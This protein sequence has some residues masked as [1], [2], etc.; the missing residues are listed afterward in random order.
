MWKD[1]N[2]KKNSKKTSRKWSLTFDKLFTTYLTLRQL[3]VSLS[4]E[5]VVYTLLK[6]FYHKFQIYLLFCHVILTF[7]HFCKF[8]TTY[9]TLQHFILYVPGLIASS[10]SPSLTLSSNTSFSENWQNCW[11]FLGAKYSVVNSG[12]CVKN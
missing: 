5:L 3:N 10:S 1:H 8:F 11:Y 9:L 4:Y 12:W 2:Q 7:I 6:I